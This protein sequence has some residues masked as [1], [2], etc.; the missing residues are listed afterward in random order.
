MLKRVSVSDNMT[1]ATFVKYFS[2][3]LR[4]YFHI[5][6]NVL[7]ENLVGHFPPAKFSGLT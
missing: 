7:V 4:A 6:A 1:F 5:W 3:C 2:L